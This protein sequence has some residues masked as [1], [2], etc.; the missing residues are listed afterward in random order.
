MS[1][2]PSVGLAALRATATSLRL[3]MEA[4]GNEAFVH[5]VDWLCACDGRLTSSLEPVLAQIVA[6][7]ERGDYLRVA[8]LLEHELQPR[9]PG[10][11]DGAGGGP[12]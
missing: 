6:A 3:G 2:D 11:P 5:L 10:A 12:S 1:P 9:L 8:D 4:Q 7:Q